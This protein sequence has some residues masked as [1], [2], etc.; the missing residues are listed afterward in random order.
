MIK[1]L[2]LWRSRTQKISPEEFSL[3][4]ATEAVTSAYT[5]AFA[6]N[7]V[8]FSIVG[9][10][11]VT[12]YKTFVSRMIDN[13]VSIAAAHT[14]QGGKIEILISDHRWS[15][16]N[17]GN[18]ISDNERIAIWQKYYKKDAAR[19]DPK[20]SGL[21]LSIIKSIADPHGFSCGAENVELGVCIW[22]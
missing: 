13:F 8:T 17:T 11:S 7:E 16:T 19:S 10:T 18:Q 5:D 1:E 15:T 20:G 2:L 22:F 3:K 4:K 12:A 6:E 14:S 21:G 9:E